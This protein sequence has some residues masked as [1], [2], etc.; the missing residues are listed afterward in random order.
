MYISGKTRVTVILYN[1]NKEKWTFWEF[2][3]EG[4]YLSISMPQYLVMKQ[5]R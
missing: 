3:E 4:R 5:Q 1:L 2:V